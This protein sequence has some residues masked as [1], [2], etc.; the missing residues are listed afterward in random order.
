MFKCVKQ[1]FSLDPEQRVISK[2]EVC[3]AELQS[4]VQVAN[5]LKL[6]KP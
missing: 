6:L 4:L 1:L 3:C 5:V 2:L